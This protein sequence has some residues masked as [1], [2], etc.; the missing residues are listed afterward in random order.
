MNPF[1]GPL[2]NGR[3]P[4]MQQTRVSAFLISAH[5]AL[6]GQLGVALPGNLH[7]GWQVEMHSQYCREVEI[8]SLLGR[9]TSWVLDPSLG[10]LIWQWG[11]AW[12]PR[13]ISGVAD[14]MQ[15]ML[16]DLAA[17]GHALHAVI[18]P[19]ALLPEGYPE[20]DP[21]ALAMRRIEFESG[22]LMQAQILF[23]KGPQLVPVRAAVAS[24]VEWRHSQIRELW[25]NML[26]SIEIDTSGRHTLVPAYK[27]PAQPAAAIAAQ[28]SV[29]IREP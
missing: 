2:E 18:R 28:P 19:A 22:R 12:V 29:A 5:G 21:F 16:I 11:L 6:A 14:R 9:A 8:L 1:L 25:Q 10:F 4:A 20:D 27:A 3:I 15:G 13:P 26:H 17:F 23:L 24:A 7:H